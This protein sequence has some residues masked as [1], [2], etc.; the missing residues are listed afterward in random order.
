MKKLFTVFLIIFSC[1]VFSQKFEL[2]KVSVEELKEKRH[3]LDSSASAAVLYKKGNSYF[4][5]QDSKWVIITKVEVRLKIYKKSGYNHANISIPYYVGKDEKESVIFSDAITY[6]L[7]GDRI[8]KTK[9]LPEGEFTEKVNKNR[10]VKKIVLPNVEEGSVIEYKY[11]L[12]SPFISLIHVWNF[13]EDIPSDKV[14]YIVNIPQLF[15]YNRIINSYLPIAEKDELKSRT[16]DFGSEGLTFYELKSTYTMENVPPFVNEGY[17]DNPINHVSYIKHELASATSLRGKTHEYATDWAA[18]IKTIYHNESFGKELEKDSYFE[19]DIQE[20]I[21]GKLGEKEVVKAIFDYVKGRMSSNNISGYDCEGS[22]KRAYVEK[23]GNVAEINLMLTAMLRYAGLKANPVI[24]ST[25]DNGYVSFMSIMAFNYVIAAVELSDGVVL[26]DATDKDA[27]PDILPIKVLNGTGYIIRE[28]LSFKEIDLMPVTASQESVLIEAGV[29]EKGIVEGKLQQ[30]FYNYNALVHKKSY[31]NS[32]DNYLQDLE[33]RFN[34]E[35]NSFAEVNEDIVEEN[36]TFI[37]KNAS[38]VIDDKIY[39]S[40]MLFYT[41]TENPFKQEKRVYPVDFVFPR[42]TRYI[43]SIS[44][45]Q[46]YTVESVPQ[47]SS[48]VFNELGSFKFNVSV[49][50]NQIQIAVTNRIYEARIDSQYYA[51]LKEFY[52]GMVK[53]QTE[54]IVLVKKA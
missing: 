38:D 53:K 5:I 19:K 6:N 15:E 27:M 34:I 31:K 52:A 41:M 32:K 9:L 36:L 12:K 51:G 14:E 33:R 35:I 30:K 11:V 3:P 26:L 8:V 40:P 45:P 10:K 48:L 21:K 1:S 37:Y 7:S 39:I 22:I 13:Q 42:Q 29:N 44:I 23:T 54:K 20:V 47:S 24:L 46:G 50:G 18:V 25:R 43:I 2:G 49:T 4:D 28:D 16:V 17:I